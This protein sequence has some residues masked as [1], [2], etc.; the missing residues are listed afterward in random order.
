MV[1]FDKISEWQKRVISKRIDTK[2]LYKI[3]KIL[4][5]TRDVVSLVKGEKGNTK[6]QSIKQTYSMEEFHKDL[7]KFTSNTNVV[8]CSSHIVISFQILEELNG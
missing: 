4:Y 7:E 5:G 3:A 8:T 1:E 2:K 6:K